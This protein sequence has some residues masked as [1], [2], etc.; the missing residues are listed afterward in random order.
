[1]AL[2]TVKE[3]FE[4]MPKVF[5]ADRAAGVDVVFQLHITGKEAG[6][7]QIVVKKGAC[8]IS[9]GIHD[10]PSVRLTMTDMDWLSMCNGQL[11]GMSAFMSGKL[12]ASGNVMLAQQIPTLFPLR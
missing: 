11:D 2:E 12:K 1:M 3:V 5:A 7:W 4:T 8:E 9:E 10:N 6:D